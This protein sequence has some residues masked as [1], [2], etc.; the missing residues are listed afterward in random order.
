MSKTQRTDFPSDPFSPPAAPA[1]ATL[2]A[3]V[4][5]SGAVEIAVA[6]AADETFSTNAA[7][8]AP[9]EDRHRYVM[10]SA[11][12]LLWYADVQD[13][14][15]DHPCLTWKM[16]L[17]DLEA[18]QR[19]LPLDLLPGEAYK[20]AWYR[21]RPQ[22][23]RDLCDCIG[24]TSVRAGRSY[25]QEFRCLDAQG[26]TRWLHED[27]QVETITEGV[28]WRVVGVCTDITERKRIERSLQLSEER[29][30]LAIEGAGVGTWHWDVLAG[31]LVWSERCKTLFGLSPD[32]EMRYERF[33]E[34][35]HPDDREAVE[36]A[37]VRSLDDRQDYDIEHR[38]F[39]PDGSLHWLRAKGRGY[40]DAAGQPLRFEGII[41]N[42]DADKRAQAEIQALN[43]RLRRAMSETHHRVK[44]NLQVIASLVDMQT[45]TGED[46]VS[47]TAMKRIGQ[48]VSTLASI[49]DLLTQQTRTSD[50]VE[51]VSTRAVLGRLVS[52]IQA[53][54]GPRRIRFQA[55]D[56]R[57]PVREGASLGLL[58]NELL[59]NALKHG[60]GEIALTLTVT[61]LQAHL[62]VCDDGPGFPAGFDAARGANTGLELV[63]SVGRLD[64]RG[65]LTFENRPEGGARVTLRFPIPP[66][67]SLP[68]PIE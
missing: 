22:E 25:E 7:D 67:N 49:H 64:L 23:D 10:A 37:I 2:E 41:Q 33:V 46:M 66:P 57:L 30:R 51:S 12:C 5:V 19:F 40:Y 65:R 60:T 42:I 11:R 26:Q 27:I 9:R 4:S 44:N 17:P 28:L 38:T 34:M 32:A 56:T 36:R 45:Q 48:H 8:A 14:H 1:Y 59:N 50:D 3:S 63:D 58:V 29:Q 24:T 47:V 20:D 21:A 68:A 15:P 31:T 39:W 62:E 61:G 43:V 53:T 18:A 55:D 35:L 52:L 6:N 13:D 54:S 16:I